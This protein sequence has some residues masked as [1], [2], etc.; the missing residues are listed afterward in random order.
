MLIRQRGVRMRRYRHPSHHVHQSSINKIV[1]I[2]SSLVVPVLLG[3]L[4]IFITIYQH[5]SAQEDRR[6]DMDRF[7]AERQEDQKRIA[8]TTGTRMEYC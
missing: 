6:E 3:S 8:N 5:T 1:R 4:T 2:S 7:Q